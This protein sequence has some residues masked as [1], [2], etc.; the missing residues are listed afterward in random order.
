MTK[1]EYTGEDIGSEVLYALSK[2]LYS[3]ANHVVREYL[4]NAVDA[5]P[6]NINMT[7]QGRNIYIY[8]DGEGMDEDG[9]HTCRK[10]GICY[11][12]PRRHVG[13]RGIGVW[14]G[15]IYAKKL[16]VTTSKKRVGKRYIL[17]IDFENIVKDICKGREAKDP[18]EARKILINV[19]SKHVYLDEDVEE[20]GKHY[21]KVELNDI[22]EHGEKLVTDE[23]ELKKYI[24][25][26]LPVDFPDDFVHKGQISD[27]L[28]QYVPDYRTVKVRFNDEEIFKPYPD[29]KNIDLLPPAHY[30]VLVG[31][32]QIGFMWECLHSR[33]KMIKDENAGL[34]Y[35]VKGFTV[36][37][38]EK[39]RVLW[40]N[41]DAH[42]HLWYFGEIHVVDPEITPNSAREDLEGSDAQ[43]IFVAKM[44]EK[45]EELRKKARL[46]SKKKRAAKKVKKIEEKLA[47]TLPDKMSRL[48]ELPLSDFIGVKVEADKHFRE[49]EYRKGELKAVSDRDKAKIEKKISEQLKTLSSYRKRIGKEID[50]R[51]ALGG[52]PTKKRRPRKAEKGRRP[53][54]QEI[55]KMALGSEAKDVLRVV[56][57]ILSDIT[58]EDVVDKLMGDLRARIKSMK[59]EK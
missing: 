52:E 22:T 56:V 38:A 13:F 7:V 3:D 9:I 48:G 24:G 23:E 35:K 25:S 20:E 37:T 59:S 45:I 6:E 32:K 10:V 1:V 31:K 41:R 8:D 17:T 39:S 42:F 43:R 34:L 11:K 40:E 55:D 28:S 50:R 2:G 26:T 5:Y 46:R 36:G 49:L 53:Y 47:T 44:R 14:A 4:Q 15:L 57:E 33:H 30:I 21:T 54:K 58:D 27:F 19:L 18:A 51:S 29:P 16:V 12:D